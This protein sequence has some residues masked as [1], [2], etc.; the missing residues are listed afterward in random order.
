MPGAIIAFIVG[1]ILVSTSGHWVSSYNTPGYYGGSYYYRDPAMEN[2]GIACILLAV[3]AFLT[4]LILFMVWLYQAWSVV[5]PDYDTPTPGQAV[6]LLFVPFFHLYWIFRAIP[7]LSLALDR[8]MN[9]R[10]RYRFGSPGS[11]YVVGIVACIFF[12]IPYV[13]LAIAPIL[14]LVWMNI[15]NGAKNRY[16][17]LRMR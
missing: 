15:A 16:L 13:N 9:R 1:I 10:D 17:A 7:G 8:E 14:L 3:S 11:G 4:G 6:G 2:S 12:L 5:P